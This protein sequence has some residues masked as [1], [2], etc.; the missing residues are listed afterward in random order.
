[1]GML[2]CLTGGLDVVVGHIYSFPARRFKI[3]VVYR[4]C[5]LSNRSH[6]GVNHIMCESKAALIHDM[7]T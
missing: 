7:R 2:W 5:Y 3:L 4:A 1:M 6:C